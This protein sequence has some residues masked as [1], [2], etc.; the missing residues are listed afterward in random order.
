M[1]TSAA[2]SR[3]QAKEV[4]TTRFRADKLEPKG[5]WTGYGSLTWPY[6]NVVPPAYG[7]NLSYP[8]M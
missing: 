5:M 8:L 1:Q 4:G 6:V 3:E 7:M 2:S